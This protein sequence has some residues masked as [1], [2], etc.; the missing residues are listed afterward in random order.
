MSRRVVL[1]VAALL[2][3]LL[4]LQAVDAAR[5]IR[6]V[7]ARSAERGIAELRGAVARQAAR[8]ER[9]L[10]LGKAHARYL[11]SLDSVSA[12]LREP[13]P[14]ALE[15]AG[16]D[17]AALLRRFEPLGGATVLDSGGSERLRVERMGGGVALVPALLLR[18]RADLERAR[19]ALRLAPEE[20]SLSPLEVDVARVDV[21]EERRLVLRYST[22]VDGEGGGALVLSVYAAPF[23]DEIERLHPLPGASMRLVDATGR[24]SPSFRARRRRRSSRGASPSPAPAARPSSRLPRAR[25]STGRGPPGSSSHAPPW[26]RWRGGRPPSAA[27]PSRS[28]WASSSPSPRSSSWGSS[29]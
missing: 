17:V 4:V 24:R 11:A 16:R 22:R 29:S 20:V 1:A 19:A 25:A 26:A 12:L 18:E 14:E 6:E 8:L 13:A 23:L 3:G 15:R 10:E 2:G 7:S 28:G 27:R 21:A 5:R 9:D